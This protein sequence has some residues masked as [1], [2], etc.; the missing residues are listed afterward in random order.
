MSEEDVM[1]TGPEIGDLE[2]GSPLQPRTTT[3]ATVS[4]STPGIAE[5]GDQKIS[6]S[7]RNTAA[8]GMRCQSFPNLLH[9][10]NSSCTYNSKNI[11][12]PRV[13]P[14]TTTAGIML[15]KAV[16][17]NKEKKEKMSENE[18]LMA[19]IDASV[20]N[21]R[22]TWSLIILSLFLVITMV[23]TLVSSYLYDGPELVMPRQYETTASFRYDGRDVYQEGLFK[24]VHGK[25]ES[26]G[27]IP[28]PGCVAFHDKSR[29]I[30]QRD[31]KEMCLIDSERVQTLRFRPNDLAIG[32]DI[33][34]STGPD[35]FVTLYQEG[36]A[37]QNLFNVVEKDLWSYNFDEISITYIRDHIY[38]DSSQIM[39]EVEGVLAVPAPCV[40]FSGKTASPK[41]MKSFMICGRSGVDSVV[42]NRVSFAQIGV[43]ISKLSADFPFIT[44]GELTAVDLYTDSSLKGPVLS[45]RADDKLDMSKQD[46]ISLVPGINGNGV[47]TKWSLGMCALKMSVLSHVEN[48]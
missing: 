19:S 21:N 41:D 6:K 29:S 12:S 35:S 8:D 22:A 48:M 23:V 26:R 46:F 14:A 43:D 44:T 24:L 9:I 36:K 31:N 34:L 32:R 28:E 42:M 38:S 13:S 1:M 33:A 16:M 27:K 17:S 25:H 2:M 18:K 10:A 4:T 3:T 39:V 11:N 40:L 45:L 30:G 37:T 15:M 20:S 5:D 47:I 7:S